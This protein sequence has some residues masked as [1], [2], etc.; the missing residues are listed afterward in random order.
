MPT[1]K[2]TTDALW[3]AG[4]SAV[5]TPAPEC[6]PPVYAQ[7]GWCT[8]EGDKLCSMLDRQAWLRDLEHGVPYLQGLARRDLDRYTVPVYIKVVED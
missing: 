8:P 5:A 1:S 2:Q 6:T 4:M 7:V 3:A